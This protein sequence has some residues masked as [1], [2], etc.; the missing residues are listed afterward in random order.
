MDYPVSLVK[1]C[2]GGAAGFPNMH[3]GILMN[4]GP[5][6]MKGLGMSKGTQLIAQTA[7]TDGPVLPAHH[8]LPYNRRTALFEDSGM[9]AVC[10]VPKCVIERPTLRLESL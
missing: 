4:T 8:L 3:N 5:P 7:S 6:L 10:E 9:R 2:T 1:H